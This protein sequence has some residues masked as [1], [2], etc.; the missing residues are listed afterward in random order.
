MKSP[1]YVNV[2]G[3]LFCK[4]GTSKKVQLLQQYSNVPNV[5]PKGGI[6]A[7]HRQYVPPYPPSFGAAGTGTQELSV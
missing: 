5:P 4:A 1:S 6:K 2:P 3:H 7:E